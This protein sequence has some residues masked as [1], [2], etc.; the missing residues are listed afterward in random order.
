MNVAS[1]YEILQ[2][3]Y[4]KSNAYTPAEC[5]PWQ[6]YHSLMQNMCSL[7]E[8]SKLALNFSKN[9][10]KSLS[11]GDLCS[12]KGANQRKVVLDNKMPMSSTWIGLVKYQ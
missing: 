9:A 7:F 5:D 3:N 6:I 1:P 2:T 11:E 10:S 8:C 4:F 12:N